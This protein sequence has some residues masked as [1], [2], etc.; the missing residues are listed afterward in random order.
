VTFPR[1]GDWR[2]VVPNWAGV[3][4]IAIPPPIMRTISVGA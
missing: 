1:R 4:G 3:Q 2:L